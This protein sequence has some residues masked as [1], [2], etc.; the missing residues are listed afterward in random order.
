MAIRWFLIL[1]LS[2]CTDQVLPEDTLADRSGRNLPEDT[3]DSAL[4]EEETEEE[5]EQDTD[6]EPLPEDDALILAVD[7]PSS[8]ACGESAEVSIEVQNEGWRAWNRSEGYKLGTVDDSD[9]FYTRDTRVWLPE[10][11][12][13]SPGDSWVFE[14]EIT[15][16]EEAGT[17]VTDWQ[18]VHEAVRWFGESTSLNID[19]ECTEPSTPSTPPDLSQVTWLSA[20]VSSW[21]AT[22][23]LESVTLSSSGICLDY[24]MAD[25]WPVHDYNGVDVVANPWIFIWQDGQWYAGTWE[26]LRPGQTCKNIDA[27]AGS[28]IKQSPFGEHS[29]WVPT[30]GERYWFMVSGLARYS[31]RNVSE[32]SNLVEVIWP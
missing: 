4:P 25:T 30:S 17:Y 23:T 13:V 27:V 16:P 24:D 11:A 3:G 1:C 9:P 31:E 10:G 5:E 14:F 19:V 20:D 29:G 8:L 26:W 7:F 6:E 28:H 21:P 2:G 12:S 32:R 22:A 15:A 18:M